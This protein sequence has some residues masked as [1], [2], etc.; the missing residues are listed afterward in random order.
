M[1]FFMIFAGYEIGRHIFLGVATPPRVTPLLIAVFFFGAGI[2]WAFGSY[3]LSLGRRTESPTLIAE[4]KHRQVDVLS[5]CIVL[6]ALV[7]NFTGIRIDFFGIGID[8]IAAMLVLIFIAHTSWELLS[9]GMRMLLDASL[10]PGTLDKVRRIISAQPAVVTINHLVGRNAGRF[11]FIQTEITVRTDDL[12]K[13]HRISEAIEEDIHDQ[14]PHVERVLIH[15]RPHVSN[16]F[17]LAV[18]LMDTEG[19]LSSNFGASEFVAFLKIRRQDRAIIQR[20]IEKNVHR[21]F[22]KG[23]G[24]KMAEWLIGEGVDELAGIDEIRNKGPG[25]VLANAGIKIHI[26]SAAHIDSVLDTIYPPG[27]PLE[28]ATD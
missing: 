24:I 14:I 25:Y 5:T 26:V 28:A 17:I 11:R 3:T 27:S 6:M 10:D 12:Q 19:N 16:F 22:E 7:L 21:H 23:R 18:P 2:T 1:A 13:A 4:G 9:D 20:R 15:F 8:R